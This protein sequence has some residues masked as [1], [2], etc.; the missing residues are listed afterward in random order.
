MGAPSPTRQGVQLSAV[1]RC[2]LWSL[3]RFLIGSI[4]LRHYRFG[5]RNRQKRSGYASHHFEDCPSV[6]E[7]ADDRFNLL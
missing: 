5:V 7:P 6:Q 4:R 1:K 2:L 3:N